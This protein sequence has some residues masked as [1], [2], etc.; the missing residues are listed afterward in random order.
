VQT[1]EAFD[2]LVGFYSSTGPHCPDFV[3]L[4]GAE[5]FQRGAFIH[6]P[7]L[8]YQVQATIERR[9]SEVSKR[10]SS[11]HVT[12]AL[13]NEQQS[14]EKKM[15]SKS[16]LFGGWRRLILLTFPLLTVVFSLMFMTTVQASASTV[17]TSTTFP[18]SL[19]VFV[20]CAAGGT[21]ENVALSGNL[22]D[23]FTV[24]FDG[25]GGFHLYASDNPQG[26]SGV[27]LTTGNK[28]QGT[29]I[30]LFDAQGT[31]G[32]TSVFTFVNNFRIIGS[33]PGNNLL[34]HENFHVTVNPDGTV[35]SFHDDFSITC[36]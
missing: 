23:L 16:I 17:T 3:A 8:S 25:N 22:H 13:S 10:K 32:G 36:M 30:T 35:T 29:G 19:T 15:N 33:G 31:A 24:T 4:V 18:I 28:Y 11:E 27:G 26:V 14:R 6:Q 34:V 20:P 2:S 12:V 5:L 21:G 7:S 9:C 1:R